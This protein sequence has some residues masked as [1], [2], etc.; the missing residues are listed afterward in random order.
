MQI[1]KWVILSLFGS[2]LVSIMGC[3]ESK[4]TPPVVEKAANEVTRTVS[5]ASGKSV[6]IGTWENK[7]EDGDGVPDEQDDYP[8]DAD[9]SRYAEFIEE[10]FNNNLSVANIINSDIPFRVAGSVQENQDLDLFK[11]SVNGRKQVSVVLKSQSNE[12]L[13]YITIFDNTGN[14]LPRINANFELVGKIKSTVSFT[15]PKSGNYYLVVGDEE[16][17]GKPD[18]TYEAHLFI[19]EDV[20]LVDDLIESAFGLNNRTSDTD[21]DTVKDGNEF[22]VYAFD[23][24]FKHDPDNDDIPNWLDDDSDGDKILDKIEKVFDF[25]FDGLA[26]FVDLDSDGNGD[27]DAQEVGS[28]ILSPTDTDTDTDTDYD[29]FYD[30]IDVDDD[31][32]GLLDVNDIAPLEKIKTA[33]PGEAGYMSI[34][35]VEYIYSGDYFQDINIADEPHILIGNN[36][37]KTGI[38]IFKLKNKPMPINLSLTASE[39]NKFVLPKDVDELYFMSENKRSN[40]IK[41]QY[42][43]RGISIIK[44]LENEYYSEG[45]VIYLVGKNF[46]EDSVVIIGDNEVKPNIESTSR[47]S[48]TLP[49]N[50]QPEEYLYIRTS[51][52]QSNKQILKVGNQ[53]KLS[54]PLNSLVD[55]ALLFVESFNSPI[56]KVNYFKDNSSD[57]VVGSGHDIV[58]VYSLDENQGLQIYQYQV[59]FGNDAEIEL[60]PVNAALSSVWYKGGFKSLVP[61]DKWQDTYNQL[62]SL[63]EVIELSNFIS[64]NN[65]NLDY[66]VS[67]IEQLSALE[68]VAI[69]AAKEFIETNKVIFF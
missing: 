50:L 48:F 49:E 13:P 10:E 2:L 58:M 25:D 36:L 31:N 65:Q 8:F 18:F 43:N 69:T 22:Y 40:I 44:T 46:N 38:L 63:T 68:D 6:R 33:L 12:F 17:R 21:S 51:Y 9:K 34:N 28:D 57:V 5:D 23:D 11:F 35:S 45:E 62:I 16:V 1:K 39:A 15:I 3:N 24:V 37:D 47:L 4:E 67:K 32:D 53:V 20:D 54:L 27:S 60:T 26:S 41:I 29:G 42:S 61:Q 14:S 56:K 52:G 59:I 7:D 30:Y 64:E 66:A 55:S 19:D